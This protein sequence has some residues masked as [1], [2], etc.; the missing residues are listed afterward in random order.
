MEIQQ[1]GFL[2]YWFSCRTE[3]ENLFRHLRLRFVLR[4][5]CWIGSPDFLAQIYLA[6]VLL[7]GNRQKY[8]VQWLA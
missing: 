1:Q 7:P 8:S 6:H 3:P 4:A 5:G 2:G